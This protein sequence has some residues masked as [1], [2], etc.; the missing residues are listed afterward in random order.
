MTPTGIS[1]KVVRDRLEYLD[2]CLEELRALPTGSLEEFRADRR[3]PRAADSLLRHGIQ[4]LFDTAR[5]L[6]AKGFGLGRLEYKEIATE[7]VERGLVRDAALGRRF[8]EIAGYR[9][10][11]IHHYE[12]VSSEELFEIARRDLGDLD[13]LAG[14]LRAAAKRLAEEPAAEGPTNGPSG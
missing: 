9:N 5:H 8:S 2:R 14:E 1:L 4:A 13:A 10:R 6:L 12:D 7:A 3:T 11:L